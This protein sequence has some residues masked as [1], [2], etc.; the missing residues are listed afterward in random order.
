MEP[1]L[2]L[3]DLER[4]DDNIPQQE[5]Y[6]LIVDGDE[7]QV[8]LGIQQLKND[9]EKK[10]E[11]LLKIGDLSACNFGKHLFQPLFHVRRGGKITVLP[12]ALGESEYQFVT[13]LKTWCDDNS[14]KL[15]ADG[16]E[17]FLLRNMSRGKGV[18]FFEA[19]NFH[20]DFIL[21]LLVGG[22][23]Y[24]TFIEPHGLLH[25]GPAS[26][27]VLF[28]KRIKDIERRLG[29]PAVVL[30]SFILSWTSFVHLQWGI[31]KAGFE[32]RHVLFMQ[33]DRTVYIDKLIDRLIEGVK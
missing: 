19:A 5:F 3:R 14:A 33:D 8:I 28:A 25:E 10:K 11:T 32:E 18:G 31:D 26:E 29:D 23:Q 21:W 17:L 9:L 12:V 27:K 30:N 6:Q 24:V 2:E 22:K 16:A 15:Q 13:D 20:P 7:N 4:D 1:R